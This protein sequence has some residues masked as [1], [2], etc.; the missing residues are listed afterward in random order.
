MLAPV[1]LGHY[2]TNCTGIF[3]S[4]VGLFL[5]NHAELSTTSKFPMSHIPTELK[6]VYIIPIPRQHLPTLL[7]ILRM[8]VHATNGVL[9]RMG[10][11]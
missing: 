9:T 3:A 1:F 4:T 2:Q 7:Q 10:K 5:K 8:V 11:L 6:V